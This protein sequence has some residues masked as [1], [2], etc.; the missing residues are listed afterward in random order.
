M[1]VENKKKNNPLVCLWPEYFLRVYFWPFSM[2]AGCRGTLVSQGWATWS[3]T[4]NTQRI[5]PQKK[6]IL[7]Q[8]REESPK[9]YLLFLVLGLPVK[10]EEKML[11]L[12]FLHPV[13]QPP[14]WA[15][16]HSW[17]LCLPNTLL[18][19]AVSQGLPVKLLHFAGA[20]PSPGMLSLH[21]SLKSSGH[22]RLP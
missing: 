3:Q 7:Q 20:T 16:S 19:S 22:I 6:K 21:P 10:V 4:T 17:S 8:L 14:F 18:N 13:A 11:L 15:L 5:P 12:I 9:I 1:E 2:F